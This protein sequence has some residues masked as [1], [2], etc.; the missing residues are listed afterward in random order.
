MKDAEGQIA[1]D[2][3]AYEFLCAPESLLA[4]LD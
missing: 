1:L 4:F 2:L 3:A